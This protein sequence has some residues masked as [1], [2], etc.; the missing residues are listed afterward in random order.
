MAHGPHLPHRYHRLLPR[1][2]VV[3][4]NLTVV[5]LL[6]TA[7]TTYVIKHRSFTLLTSVHSAERYYTYYHRRQA[8]ITLTR[9]HAPEPTTGT[10][11]QVMLV[12]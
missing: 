8:I 9:L 11:L 2:L 10:W 12:Q 1:Q 7:L 5:L 6:K 4:H 3:L